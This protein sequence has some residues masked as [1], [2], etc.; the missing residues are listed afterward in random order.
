MDCAAATRRDS[1]GLW[2]GRL[3]RVARSCADVGHDYAVFLLQILH[4]STG[5]GHLPHLSGLRFTAAAYCQGRAR[6]PLRVFDLLLERFNRAVQRSTVDDGRWHIETSIAHLKTTMQMD[7]L[8]C[9]TVP[10]VLKELP[11]FIIYGF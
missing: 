7:I 6:L 4:S 5:C 9:K 11:V 2:G 3:Y 8:H 10:G 1:R